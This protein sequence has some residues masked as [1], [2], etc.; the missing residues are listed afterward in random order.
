MTEITHEMAILQAALR[1]AAAG[2]A[3][4]PARLYVREDG[5]FGKKGV[6][7]IADW[8]AASTTDAAVISGW[9][10]PGGAWEGQAL[11]V[12]CG[13]SGIAG[14]DQDVSDGKNG[15][16]AWEA[17]EPS[18]AT[19]RVRT[20]SGGVHDYYRADSDHP[21]TVDN[22]GAVA[23][24]VDVRG[25]GGFLFAPPTRDPRGGSWRWIEGE[26]DWEQLP[27][28]PHV[29]IERMATAGERKRP[30]V[31][32]E[33]YAPQV[34]SGT[35][36]YAGMPERDQL[37]TNGQDFGPGGGYK[38]LSAAA[39]LVAA[40]LARFRALTSEGSAR[41]HVV[42]Q[43][44]GVLA[45]HGVGVFWTYEGALASIMEVAE[46]NGMIAVHG[47]GYVED[48]AR[49]GLEYGM[50]QLWQPVP[51][52]LADVAVPAR[53]EP[54]GRLRRALLKRSDVH[55]LPDLVPL[56]S[57]VLYRDSVAVLSGKFG[58]YKSFVAVSMAA[59]LAAGTPWFG[60]DVPQAVPVIY[61]AAEGAYGIKRRLDAWERKSGLV[62]P[63]SFALISVSVRLNRPADV[64]ELEELITETGAQLLVF[65]TLHMST[66]GV[67]E[68]DAGAMG[69]V[70][71][72][73]Q[74]LR[75]RFGVTSLLPHHTGH[76]GERARGSSSVE[77]DADTAFVIKIDGEDRSTRSVR[78]LVHRKSKDSALLP[79]VP[80]F[81]ET[82][83][84]TGSAIV[85]P[86]NPFEDVAG[87]TGGWIW[88]ID[89]GGQQVSVPRMV[90]EV[91]SEHG[92]DRGLTKSDVHGMVLEKYFGGQKD[93]L[94]KQTWG[95]GWN[96]A[97]QQYSE[98]V[99]NVGG[100]RFSADPLTIVDIRKSYTE[101]DE[102]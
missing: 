63:D 14:I 9:Y 72:V 97:L 94:K 99:V 21:F 28:V 51:E 46:A 40:E 58:T 36:P 76:A 82:V 85:R 33:W 26:P 61:A 44:L 52:S 5:G 88:P 68:N 59:S 74:D 37:F 12:D 100:E 75:D 56:I 6:S 60:H 16:K 22:T 96:R 18:A 32:T 57:D 43:R 67:D 66:P 91:L 47:Q 31:R 89:D 78:T 55:G 81:L 34:T 79:D 7:P 48:Q 83:D 42:S 65:D 15:V 11:C 77:D 101:S 29:V 10:G 84:G 90:L 80:L 93:R 71:S 41:S 86:R 98:V 73:L 27:R 24:G 92:H 54:S 69:N 4:F 2:V 45:G 17:L 102:S 38:K 3:V 8:D 13:K 53:A 87:A 95:G 49:R 23:D 19:W 70:M 30:K 62:I 20:P 35:Q 64:T 25:Q 39:E 50:R 1:Y